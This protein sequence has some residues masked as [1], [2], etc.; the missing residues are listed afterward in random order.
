MLC[1]VL[2]PE[3]FHNQSIEYKGKLLCDV[4]VRLKFIEF[5]KQKE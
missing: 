3:T 2:E 5:I 1:P 4:F